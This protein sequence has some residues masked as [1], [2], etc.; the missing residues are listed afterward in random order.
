MCQDVYF[1]KYVKS[2]S[3]YILTLDEIIY[4][5]GIYEI[6]ERLAILTSH[7]LFLK[8]LM[9]MLMLFMYCRMIGKNKFPVHFC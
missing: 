2:F 6:S 4:C 5:Q 7:I 8:A 3:N 9:N 1:F